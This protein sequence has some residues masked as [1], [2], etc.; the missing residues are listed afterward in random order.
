MQAGRSHRGCFRGRT[1]TTSGGHAGQ[2]VAYQRVSGAVTG[3]VESTWFSTTLQQLM[4]SLRIDDV[5]LP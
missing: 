3:I 2:G 1:V 5:S 4:G